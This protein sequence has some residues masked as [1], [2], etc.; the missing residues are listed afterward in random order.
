VVKR[1]R[2]SRVG[3]RVRIERR[4]DGVRGRLKGGELYSVNK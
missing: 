1:R 2:S 3:E 4:I